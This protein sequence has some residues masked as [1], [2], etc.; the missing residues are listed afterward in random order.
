MRF[1]NP[2]AFTDHFR[3]D[4]LQPASQWVVLTHAAA[5]ICVHDRLV[6]P[7]FATFGNRLDRCEIDAG[8]AA[9][10]DAAARVEA[11]GDELDFDHLEEQLRSAGLP[12]L[13]EHG[14]HKLLQHRLSWRLHC[15]SVGFA[16]TNAPW[17]R[18]AASTAMVLVQ[19]LS[20]LAS[21]S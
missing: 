18:Q 19:Y 12:E 1:A 14:A 4:K 16:S 8:Q 10:L 17:L 5:H 11:R 20:M 13:P 15:I 9:V 21:V 7:W 6:E 3:S 2:W